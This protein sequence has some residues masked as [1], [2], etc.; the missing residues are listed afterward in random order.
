MESNWI[1]ITVSING[2]PEISVRAPLPDMAGVEGPLSVQG[3]IEP[4]IHALC[5]RVSS[6]MGSGYVVRSRSVNSTGYQPQFIDGESIGSIL[7]G[8]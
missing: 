1:E 8:K 7:G 5:A 4:R 2:A 6:F 3:I